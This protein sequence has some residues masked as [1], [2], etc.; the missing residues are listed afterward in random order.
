MRTRTLVV[1]M[2]NRRE[3]LF[4]RA[5]ARVEAIVEQILA[6]YATSYVGRPLT[7][8]DIRPPRPLPGIA[9]SI[10]GDLV[11]E[12]VHRESATDDLFVHEVALFDVL[13]RRFRTRHVRVSYV[14]TTWD[15]AAPTTTTAPTISP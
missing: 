4:E 11:V 3:W 1:N 8:R 13:K 6:D 2:A 7:R 10:D 12:F 9:W 14:N 15:D 5:V